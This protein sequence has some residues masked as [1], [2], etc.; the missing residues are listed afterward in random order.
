MS[1]TS[2]QLK[3]FAKEAGADLIGVAPIERFKGAPEEMHPATLMPEVQSVV[4]IACRILRGTLRGIEEGT[5]WPSYAFFG[6]GGLGAVIGQVCADVARFI[7]SH[8]AEAMRVMA[9]AALSEAGPVR[10][11]VRP[12]APPPD[13]IPSFR[14]A[15]VAAGLGEIGYAKVLLTPQFGPR[16]RVGMILTD[17]R[18]DPDPLYEGSLCDRCMK[19]VTDCPA[20]AI[21]PTETVSINIG[22]KPCE[23]ADLDTGKCKLSHF[24]VN[25]MISPFIARDIPGFHMDIAKQKMTWLEAHDFGWALAPRVRYFDLVSRLHGQYWPICGARGCVRACADHLEK[26]GKIQTFQQP[27]RK[28]KP[29]LLSA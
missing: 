13:T 1:L 18:L 17:A 27:L 25:R 5:H 6:Y 24:G 12:G 9:K 11:P 21:S 7:E 19:C 23:W 16:Q 15:A 14:F 2:L 22:G 3:E 26:Q 29:W 10:G 28:R 20:G 8:G 4:M